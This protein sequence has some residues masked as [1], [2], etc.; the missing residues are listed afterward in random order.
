VALTLSLLIYSGPF[1]PYSDSPTSLYYGFDLYCLS[2]I[3]LVCITVICK[4]NIDGLFLR[5][6]IPDS[7]VGRSDL[8][9]LFATKSVGGP[10]TEYKTCFRRQTV[11]K[12][13]VSLSEIGMHRIPTPGS[14]VGMWYMIQMCPN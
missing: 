5:K 7:E 9:R 13:N 3:M 10:A 11:G 8:W 12:M 14:E 4:S 2:T 1:L 6:R